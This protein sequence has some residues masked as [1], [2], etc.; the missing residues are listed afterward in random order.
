MYPVMSVMFN[1]LTRLVAREDSVY[2]TLLILEFSQWSV[3]DNSSV[4]VLPCCV[5]VGNV[6][7]VSKLHA[8]SVALR[9]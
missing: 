6:F 9:L 8:A 2:C 5:D 3:N 4:L 7:Y 1:Q